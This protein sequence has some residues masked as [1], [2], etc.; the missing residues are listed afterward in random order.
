VRGGPPATE[1]SSTAG[2]GLLGERLRRIGATPVPAHFDT[3]CGFRVSGVA[4][5]EAIGTEA[6]LEVLDGPNGVVRVT[7]HGRTRATPRGRPSSVLLVFGDGRGAL[8]PVIPGFVAAVTYDSTA[9]EL[10]EVAYEPADGA[11]VLALGER[12]PELRRLRQVIAAASALGAFRLHDEQERE[13]LLSRLRDAD[14]LDPSLTLYAAHAL[15]EIGG[16]AAIVEIAEQQRRR[17]AMTLF[18]VVMLA[19]G[20][21][22]TP[23]P[24]PAAVFPAVPLLA[25]GWALL[26]AYNVTLP[27]RLAAG[28]IRRHARDS[29]WTL[30]DPPGVALL[31]DAIIAREVT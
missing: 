18:D 30:F 2:G 11:L 8:L 5:A 3:R 7:P 31:R 27:G 28:D 16:Q 14:G 17:L 29:L 23:A 10:E 9:G 6:A 26:A 15:Q 13:A 19:R 1:E 22:A 12:L 24:M 25:Q 21:Q 4:V 20:P